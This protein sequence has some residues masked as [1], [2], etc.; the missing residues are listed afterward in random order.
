V[1]H[2]PGRDLLPSR[3]S[4]RNAQRGRRGRSTPSSSSTGE[5]S[6]ASALDLRR[7]GVL[8]VSDVLSPRCRVPVLVDFEHREV[9]S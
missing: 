5:R 1:G 7:S 4:T 6:H 8:L 2:R 3:R 9:G